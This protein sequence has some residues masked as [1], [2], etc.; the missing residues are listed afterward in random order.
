MIDAKQF[1][2]DAFEF[3][4]TDQETVSKII[5]KFNPKMAT[6]ANK[7]SVKL[8]KLTKD[9]I[10]EPI[11]DHINTPIKTYIF[12]NAIKR[13]KV[14]PLFKKDDAMTKSNYRPVSLLPIPSKIFEKSTFHTAL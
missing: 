7:I 14:F 8:Q 1:E 13:A 3:K 12:P 6:G 5:D 2:K 11:T 10:V 4:R 9:T